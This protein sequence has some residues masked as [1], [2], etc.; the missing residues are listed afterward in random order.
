M[1]W[2][3]L[4]SEAEWPGH[5]RLLWPS[6]FSGCLPALV[7]TDAHSAFPTLARCASS[8][9]PLR[10]MP[11][12]HCKWTGRLADDGGRRPKNS[13]VHDIWASVSLHRF[14]RPNLRELERSTALYR[15]SIRTPIHKK[16]EDKVTCTDVMHRLCELAMPSH[17]ISTSHCTSQCSDV[18]TC[19]VSTLAL[20]DCTLR[21]KLRTNFVLVGA[22]DLGVHT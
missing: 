18:A 9:R 2:S 14:R 19:T 15:T 1:S 8:N 16:A 20:L 17:G 13:R 7:T 3:E 6:A 5:K 11:S 10:R 12:T 21:H 22:C 4:K